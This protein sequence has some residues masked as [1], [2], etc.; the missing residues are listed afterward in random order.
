MYG[1]FF[2][3]SANRQ[4][5]EALN[6]FLPVPVEELVQEFAAGATPEQICAR[7]IRELQAAG[8]RHFYISNLPVSRAQAVLARI[9]EQV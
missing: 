9:L 4:T 8:A 6:G 5:L 7:S 3:R 2:Y 1:I